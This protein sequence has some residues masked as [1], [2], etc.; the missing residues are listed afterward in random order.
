MP[1]S[2]PTPAAER[3][4][5]LSSRPRDLHGRQPPW[6]RYAYIVR[7]LQRAIA[8]LVPLL[9]LG[10]DGRV[11][12]FGCADM[13]YRPL[14]PAGAEYIGADIGGNPKAHVEIAADG[15][16]PG[17]SDG[18]LDAI[19][20]TQVL[21]HVT[22]PGVYLA[23]CE[24]LLRPGGRLLLSTHGLMFYHPDP[25]D[26]WRWTCAGLQEQVSR[27]GLE[28]VHFEGIMGMA[29]TGVQLVQEAWYYRLPRRAMPAFALLMQTLAWL[30]DRIA[31]HGGR[32]LNSMVFALVAEKPAP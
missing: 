10:S 19:L 20:S 1:A 13:P 24:R 31:P 8:R 6:H 29:A 26:Y 22:D 32:E 28:V 15:T 9:A 17:L 12:D 14:F 23:E 7:E 18:S 25:V 11:L 3:P 2:P 30:A 4:R 27:A 5:F 16:V 21:E